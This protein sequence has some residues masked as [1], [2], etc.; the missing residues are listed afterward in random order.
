[1][2]E[3]IGR[4]WRAMAGGEGIEEGGWAGRKDTFS[5]AEY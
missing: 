1:M 2:C 5:Q 3:V 4:A